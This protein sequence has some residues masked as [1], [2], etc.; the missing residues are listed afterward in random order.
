MQE[1]TG[2]LSQTVL[3]TIIG[4]ESDFSA[5]PMY[6]QVVPL[7]PWQPSTMLC[8]PKG[9]TSKVRVSAWFLTIIQTS[10]C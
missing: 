4:S 8:F 10:T 3:L 6:C 5:C 7:K 2:G 1:G 9:V